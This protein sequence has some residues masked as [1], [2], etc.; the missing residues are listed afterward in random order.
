ME[1]TNNRKQVQTILLALLC[2]VLSAF[3]LN[4]LEALASEKLGLYQSFSQTIHVYLSTLGERAGALCILFAVLFVIFLAVFLAGKKLGALLYQYRYWVAAAFVVIGTVLQLNGSS[5]GMWAGYLGL[6]QDTGVLVGQSRAIRSDEWAVFSPM[7][8]SQYSNGFAYTSE[9]WRGT[10]TDMFAVYGQPVSSLLILFR[11]FQIAYL[12]LPAGNALSFYWCSRLAVMMLVSFEFGMFLTDRNKALS[13]AYMLLVA[14]APVVQWWY[15]INALVET[16]IFGQIVVLCINA[17]FEA[18]TWKARWIAAAVFAWAGP[19]FILVI[20]PS[21]QIPF[22]YVFGLICLWVII[23]K[24]KTA[25]LERRDWLPVLCAFAFIGAV[26]VVFLLKS[27]DAILAVLNSAYPGKRLVFQ[28]TAPATL[29][30]YPGNLFM[31]FTSSG[32]PANQPE[33]AT[34]FSLFPI[35]A[36]LSV[37]VM[38]KTGKKDP[39]MIILLLGL[40]FGLYTVFGMPEFLAKLT[41]MSYSQP[42]RTEIV[43]DFANLL[44]LMRALS[45][46]VNFRTIPALI[47]AA[48]CAAAVTLISANWTYQG[49]MLTGR[50]IFCMLVLFLAF[51]GVLLYW[52]KLIYRKLLFWLIICICLM[53]GAFVNPIRTGLGPI[54]DNSLSSEIASIEESDPGLWIVEDN[55]PGFTTNLFPASG[56]STL[57][58]TSTYPNME[59]WKKID[60]DGSDENIYNR[61]ANPVIILENTEPTRFELTAADSFT[62]YLNTDDLKKLDISYIYSKKDLSRFDSSTVTFDKIWSDKA[63]AIYKVIYQ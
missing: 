9:L 42:I 48:V 45:F 12:F 57:N 53:C 1:T 46:E 50:Q 26:L 56:A 23:S 14:F 3:F 34:F 29:F 31:S 37:Y 59:T 8:L 63:G 7:A 40:F 27:Q 52:N 51:A 11:P 35:G 58:S 6:P 41:L 62:V 10:V 17:F 39:V 54:A 47:T 25:K 43:F 4:F 15:S 55:E 2:A 21:W 16:L 30:R 32:L 28:D 49:Y 60:T 24:W 5:L 44:L 22:L 33:N 36:I 13:S 18:K 20:Y 19:A 61:Y 38:W